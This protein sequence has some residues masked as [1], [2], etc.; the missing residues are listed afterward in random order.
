MG[1]SMVAKL[2]LGTSVGTMP[3]ASLSG[4]RFNLFALETSVRAE[5]VEALHSASSWP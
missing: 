1:E 2:L 3:L 4:D 5:L